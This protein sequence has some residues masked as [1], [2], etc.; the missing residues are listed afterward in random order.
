MSDKL[1]ANILANSHEW[2]EREYRKHVSDWE[3][4][5]YFEII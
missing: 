4:S 2:E 1:F 3:M 5:R